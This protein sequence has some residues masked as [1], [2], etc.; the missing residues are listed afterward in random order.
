MKFVDIALL[1]SDYGNWGHLNVGSVCCLAY[2][3]NITSKYLA[4]RKTFRTKIEKSLGLKVYAQYTFRWDSYSFGDGYTM[5]SSPRY[6][7][8]YMIQRLMF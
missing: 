7:V 2:F 4:E 6:F 3:S 5:F 8:K 1:K